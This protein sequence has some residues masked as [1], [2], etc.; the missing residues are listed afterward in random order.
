MRVVG[1]VG[2]IVRGLTGR[3]IHKLRLKMKVVRNRLISWGKLGVT[4]HGVLRALITAS[5][6]GIGMKGR[7]WWP[8][9]P[10]HVGIAVRGLVV[11]SRRIHLSSLSRCFRGERFLYLESL[12][13]IALKA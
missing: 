9:P 2:V 4:T 12:L 6:E 1:V 11:T 3:A 5:V 10:L 7:V 13:K 8:S